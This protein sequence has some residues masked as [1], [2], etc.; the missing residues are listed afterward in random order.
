MI[1]LFVILRENYLLNWENQEL[2]GIKMSQL[3]NVSIN[4]G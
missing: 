2:L 1:N 4:P 3:D